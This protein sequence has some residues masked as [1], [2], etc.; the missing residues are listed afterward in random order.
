MFDVASKRMPNC[1]SIVNVSSVA[2]RLDSPAEYV[3]YA[4]SKGAIDTLTK[5]CMPMA[6]NQ[7]E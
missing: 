2:A 5:G 7:T 1:G 6:A 4:V 3:D